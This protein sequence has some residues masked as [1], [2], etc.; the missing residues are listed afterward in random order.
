MAPLSNQT[1]KNYLKVCNAYYNVI[2][3]QS[4][5]GTFT[6]E[7]LET[8][9]VC[10]KSVG[11][12]PIIDLTT[13]TPVIPDQKETTITVNLNIKNEPTPGGR[14]GNTTSTTAAR[15]LFGDTPPSQASTNR[16]VAAKDPTRS[17]T[18]QSSARSDRQ[19]RNTPTQCET[20]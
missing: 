1:T 11:E 2:N 17:T 19:N 7:K 13:D 3:G 20:S 10:L 4:M 6:I 14:S 18:E 9:L 16:A 5:D 12:Y 15:E 8:I